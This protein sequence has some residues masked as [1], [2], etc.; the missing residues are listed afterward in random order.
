VAAPQGRVVTG[1]RALTAVSEELETRSLQYIAL[2]HVFYR[3]LIRQ[4][5]RFNKIFVKSLFFEC[6]V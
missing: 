1:A 6:V 3:I 2:W 5:L 4:L